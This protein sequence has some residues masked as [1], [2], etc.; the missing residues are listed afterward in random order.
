MNHV[1]SI[2]RA[3]LIPFFM[4][5]MLIEFCVPGF[6][7]ARRLDC[8]KAIDNLSIRVKGNWES[9]SVKSLSKLEA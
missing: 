9:V 7:Y 2:R 8:Y 5:V 4:F 1:S 3:E 6:E